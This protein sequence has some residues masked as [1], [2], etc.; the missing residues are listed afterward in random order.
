MFLLVPAYPT[1]TLAVH[2]LSD[3]PYIMDPIAKLP[4]RQGQDILFIVIICIA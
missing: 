2:H 3:L 1:L 4:G